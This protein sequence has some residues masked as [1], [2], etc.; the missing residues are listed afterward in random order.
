MC[1]LDAGR[2]IFIKSVITIRTGSGQG[3]GIRGPRFSNSAALRTVKLRDLGIPRSNIRDWLW[4][5]HKWPFKFRYGWSRIPVTNHRYN[6][7][8]KDGA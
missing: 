4:R 8:V 1:F 7:F 2:S 3:E 6:R 5:Q